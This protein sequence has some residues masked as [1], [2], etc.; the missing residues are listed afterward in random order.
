MVGLNPT[1]GMDVR[2]LLVVRCFDSGICDGLISHSADSHRFC[3][4]VCDIVTSKVMRPRPDL[5]CSINRER[6]VLLKWAL[7]ILRSTNTFQLEQP[8]SH[9]LRSLIKKIV[10]GIKG[11]T[12]VLI[13]P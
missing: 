3:V 13:S 9:E 6:N 10:W 1:E 5:G 8:P 12:G 2:L 11:N 7:K 4:S